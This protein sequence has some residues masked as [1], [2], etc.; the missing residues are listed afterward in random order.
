[1]YKWVF[2]PELLALTYI[3]IHLANKTHIFIF[4]IIYTL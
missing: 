3:H 1:M 2:E 4:Y